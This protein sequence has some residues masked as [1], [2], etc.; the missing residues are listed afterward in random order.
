MYWFNQCY[1]VGICG[2]MVEIGFYRHNVPC[3][4]YDYYHVE[5]LGM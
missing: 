1:T 3:P 5:T 2:G 4:F